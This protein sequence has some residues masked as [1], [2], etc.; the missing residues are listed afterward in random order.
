MKCFFPLFVIALSLVS[1]GKITLEGNL[2]FEVVIPSGKTV[3]VRNAEWTFKEDVGYL[4]FISDGET[5]DKPF[6][7]L[8]SFNSSNLSVGK[9]IPVKTASLIQS[10]SL[11]SWK[12]T[13]AYEGKL[14]LKEMTDERMVVRFDHV[15]WNTPLGTYSMSGD[16]VYSLVF[17]HS[18]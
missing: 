12:E 3:S 9:T 1:C 10:L 18:V 7:V 8:F 14:Y 17:I 16:L 5:A 2:P 13:N 6:S 4:S 11:N 15:V